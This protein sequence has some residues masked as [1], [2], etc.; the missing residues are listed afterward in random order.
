MPLRG[1]GGLVYLFIYLELDMRVQL[2]MNDYS[3]VVIKTES[4]WAA[5][6]QAR[7]QGYIVIAAYEL[8]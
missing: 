1:I 4:I 3:V 8:L 5:I 2:V 6:A 7:Q